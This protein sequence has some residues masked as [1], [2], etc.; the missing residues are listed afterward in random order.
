MSLLSVV[1]I[2]HNE[3]HNIRRCLESVRAV[4]D[5]VVVVDSGSTDGTETI[6]QNHHVRF[7]RHDWEGFSMQKNFA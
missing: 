7:V 2:T 1:I 4:A 3:E 6:C 5:E